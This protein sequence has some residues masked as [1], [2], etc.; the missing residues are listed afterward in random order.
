MTHPDSPSA[1]SSWREA[2]TRAFPLGYLIATAVLILLAV[3]LSQGAPQA[4]AQQQSVSMPQQSASV[5]QQSVPQQSVPQQGGYEHSDPEQ[6]AGGKRLAEAE[7]VLQAGLSGLDSGIRQDLLD[8]ADCVGVFPNVLKVAFVFGGQYGKG[9][10]S[11][12]SI[13]QTWSSPASFRIEGGNVGLQIGGSATDFVLLF[14]GPRSVSK[15]LRTKFTL[16]VDA[17][18]AA[19]PAGRG[20]SG[21][22]DA[23]F[24]AEI[25]SYS[26]SRGLFAGISLDGATLRPAHKENRHLYGYEPEAR[27]L[28]GG[29]V[30]IPPQAEAFLAFLRDHSPRKKTNES[31]LAESASADEMPVMHTRP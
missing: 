28:F 16:G 21:K 23:L 10:I 22:T 2:L 9:V 31:E 25:V 4:A 26:R 3:A 8:R 11:C 30:P 14:I 5:P 29:E 12:R 15:L 20:A 7:L 1:G 27:A 24:G 18:A 13:G 19:G 17:A 6:L